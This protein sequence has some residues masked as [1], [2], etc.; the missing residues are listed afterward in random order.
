[1]SLATDYPRAELLA[2]PDWVWAHRDDPRVRIIDCARVDAYQRAHI[3]GA[4]SIDQGPAHRT[5]ALG[6]TQP[7]WLKQPDGLHLMEEETFSELMSLLGVTDETTVVA[8]DMIGS[9]WATRLWWMLRRHG[10][11]RAKVL[12]GGWHRWLSEGRP[13]SAVPTHVERAAFLSR[14]RV[15]VACDL[16]ELSQR[17][18]DP[19]MRILDARNRAEFTGEGTQPYG[20]VRIGHIPGAIHL[21]WADC[22]TRD[23]QRTFRPPAEIGEMLRERDLTADH[24]IITHCQAGIRAA[25]AA[26]VLALMGF[27]RV[28]VYDGSMQEWAN[29]HETPLVTGPD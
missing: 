21:D 13:L 25:H 20:N 14:P 5:F 15:A 6:N 23:Q 17:V 1:M 19:G 18:A 9:M 2:E 27:D 24:E 22:M 8:Y 11:D 28:R 4:V 12:N 26:F 3:P 10:H 7:G 29:R 16:A